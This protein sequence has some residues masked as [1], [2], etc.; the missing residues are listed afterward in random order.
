MTFIQQDV[1]IPS[2]FSDEHAVLGELGSHLGQTSNAGP[3]A[4]PPESRRVAPNIVN[5]KGSLC[6]CSHIVSQS[7]T[8]IF[9]SLAQFK[10]LTHTRQQHL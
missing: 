3:V 6:V 4:S 5:H 9:A 7:P 2:Y 10:F 1:I 8:M